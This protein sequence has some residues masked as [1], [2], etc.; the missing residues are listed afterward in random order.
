[1]T[2]LD[3]LVWRLRFIGFRLYDDDLLGSN[4]IIDIRKGH[5]NTLVLKTASG[6]K[7]VH[8]REVG[9]SYL[10]EFKDDEGYRCAVPKV[11]IL[12]EPN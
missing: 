2:E 5:N 9:D 4:Q 11:D 7:T 3:F 6:R 1:M 10:F 12:G 8:V